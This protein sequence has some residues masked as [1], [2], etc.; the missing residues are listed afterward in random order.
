MNSTLN[1]LLNLPGITVEGTVK[2]EGYVCFQLKILATGINCPHC[3]TSTQE[4][5]QSS[6]IL[7]RDLPTFGKPVY[8]K[9]P[10]RKFYCRRCQRYSTE[11]LKFIDWRRPPTQRYE[12]NI[13][14]RVQSSSIE[15]IGREEEL[16]SSE[17]QGI[18]SHVS[19]QKKRLVAGK[20]PQS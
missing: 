3:Q 8:L 18:F 17:I 9:V 15:Q 7:I 14:N 19:N 2:V 13:Y 1:S 20:T 10:R 12:S 16:S 11:N 6:F 5:H 4:L